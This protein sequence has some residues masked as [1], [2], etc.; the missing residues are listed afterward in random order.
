M[1]WQL[2]ILKEHTRA[3]EHGKQ[4]FIIYSKP[5][6]SLGINLDLNDLELEWMFFLNIMPHVHFVGLSSHLYGIIS[7]L[8]VNICLIFGVL[9]H[10]ISCKGLH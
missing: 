4:G 10:Q 1:E 6:F 9:Q 7:C 2:C 3:I 5:I 8:L